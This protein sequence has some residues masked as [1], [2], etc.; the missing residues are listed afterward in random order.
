MKI[1]FEFYNDIQYGYKWK[2]LKVSWNT[3]LDKIAKTKMVHKATSVICKHKGGRRCNYDFE[4][5]FFRYNKFIDRVQIEFKNGSTSLSNVPQFLS[6]QVKSNPFFGMMT[7]DRFYY[8]H[9]LDQYIEC[10]K[11]I[12]CAKPVFT[13]YQKEVSSIYST[14]CFFKQLK[15]REKVNKEIKDEIVK[16]SITE[17]LEKYG[18]EIDL[19]K[20]AEKI[21][22]TQTGKIYVFWKQGQFYIDSLVFTNDNDLK[23]EGIF[24]GNILRIRNH[25]VYYNL[26]L[27]WRNHKGILNPAWQISLK[28]IT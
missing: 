6:L 20:L 27:R 12:T 17:Y 24:N 10:D 22:K 15:H 23:L 25:N 19:K 13:Q 4:I 18:K 1:P 21:T 3:V 9:F 26:L 11:G 8:E 5:E 14:S 16:R 2:E 28:Y 7:Y